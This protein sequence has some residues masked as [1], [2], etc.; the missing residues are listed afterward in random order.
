MKYIKRLKFMASAV[1]QNFGY[2]VPAQAAESKKPESID[3]G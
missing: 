1:V 3:P 2:A